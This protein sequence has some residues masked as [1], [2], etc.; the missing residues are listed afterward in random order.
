MKGQ[1]WISLVR[2]S[3]AKLEEASYSFPGTSICLWGAAASAL[4]ILWWRQLCHK[5]LFLAPFICYLHYPL[6]WCTTHTHS[7]A[8]VH[9]II[10]LLAKIAHLPKSPPHLWNNLPSPT[11]LPSLFFF[12]SLSAYSA[13][14]NIHMSKLYSVNSWTS[15]LGYLNGEVSKIEPC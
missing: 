14:L 4:I 3:W 12:F 5:S 15:K 8:H 2:A 1:K 13:S 6:P 9:V 7:D 11:I 10:L